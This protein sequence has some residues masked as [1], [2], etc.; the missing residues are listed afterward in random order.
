VPVSKWNF[1][2]LHSHTYPAALDADTVLAQLV[3]RGAKEVIVPTTNSTSK[4]P[5]PKMTAEPKK[6]VDFRREQWELLLQS[7]PK[8]A[9]FVVDW[10]QQV[11]AVSDIDSELIIPG[12]KAAP[13]LAKNDT[14]TLRKLIKKR[15]L[16][17]NGSQ[18]R[19]PEKKSLPKKKKTDKSTA[20]G[21]PGG[22]PSD[23]GLSP[24]DRTNQEATAATRTAKKNR[25]RKDIISIDEAKKGT[26]ENK[27]IT[28][29]Q[30]TSAGDYGAEN[31]I[32]QALEGA[33]NSKKSPP[34]AADEVKTSPQKL[35]ASYSDSGS[36]S[37]DD[38]LD[39]RASKREQ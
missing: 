29:P 3:E 28:I 34:D 25:I 7:R 8:S 6:I 32:H 15:A 38:S 19:G 23:P 24:L 16:P 10:V 18:T 37:S 27:V 13:S 35:L 9:E 1:K 11:L 14:S 21:K 33:W 20:A 30:V 31:T 22:D 39:L 2:K 36:S 4:S 26:N 5:D 12:E 17:I